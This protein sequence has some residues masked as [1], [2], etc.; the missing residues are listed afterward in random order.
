LGGCL[1][2]AAYSFSLL[3]LLCFWGLFFSSLL[4]RLLARIADL[5]LPSLSVLSYASEKSAVWVG[6]LL[7]AAAWDVWIVELDS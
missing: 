4:R 6:A 7:V 3:A 1:F 2:L 5:H